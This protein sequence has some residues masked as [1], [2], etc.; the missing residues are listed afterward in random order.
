MD[1]SARWCL[2]WVVAA[3]LALAGCG[4]PGSFHGTVG[5]MTLEVKD[6]LF[7]AQKNSSGQIA[8]LVLL[9]TDKPGL[10]DAMKAGNII[11][12]MIYFQAVL[13]ET[14]SG[15]IAVPSAGD[16][17]VTDGTSVPPK[18]AIASVS[19]TDA[20]CHSTQT[21]GGA[22]G[23]IT[24]SGY[25]AEAGGELTGT[26]DATFGTTA[27]RGSGDFNAEYCDASYGASG[28]Q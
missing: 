21:V 13:S 11:S 17:T 2:M 24:L 5:G 16:Y 7:L 19:R 8:S 9:M 14:S 23:K 28:C 18:F 25:K 10:C 1:R 22:G 4:G 27:E 3:A 12:S 6:S 26:F 20:T 15:Q